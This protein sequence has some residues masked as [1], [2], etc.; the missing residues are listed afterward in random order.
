MGSWRNWW[1]DHSPET[2]LVVSLPLVVRTLEIRRHS[3]TKRD[4]TRAGGSDL[5]AEGVLLA[6]QV[7]QDLGPFLSVYASSMQSTLETAI[8]MGQA[9]TQTLEA[10]GDVPTELVEELGHL[11]R[12]GGRNSFGALREQFE[13]DPSTRRLGLFQ[14]QAWLAIAE[15]L[16]ESGTALI[17]SHGMAIE[18]GLIASAWHERLAGEP[19]FGYCEGVRLSSDGRDFFQH[20]LLRVDRAID[21]RGR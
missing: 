7:G 19:W 20:E 5:S 1:F 10:L 21:S 11:G 12:W 8:A 15:E 6:R 18:T 13:S 2:S 17:I 9:V 16:P 3:S 14:R 4:P